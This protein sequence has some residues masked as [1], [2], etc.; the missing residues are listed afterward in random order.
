MDPERFT[1][2]QFQAR[3][4]AFMEILLDRK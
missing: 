2:A 1:M 4:D 3:I